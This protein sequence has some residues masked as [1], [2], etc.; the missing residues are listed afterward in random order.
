MYCALCV[1]VFF[2]D[3]NATFL[4]PDLSLLHMTD[5]TN[6]ISCQDTEARILKHFW[7]LIKFVNINGA[8]AHDV[9]AAVL[10]IQNNE[11]AAMLMY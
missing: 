2:E 1:D 4:T 9:M 6:R 5:G 10:V 11:T 8:Y 3:K 7:K